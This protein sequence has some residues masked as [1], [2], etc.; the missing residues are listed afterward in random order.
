MGESK[1]MNIHEKIQEM[2]CELQKMKI[3]K[4]GHNRHMDYKYFEL[5]DLLPMINV[6]MQQYKVSSNIRFSKE[7]AVLTFINTEKPEDFS[8]FS[9]PMA[10]SSLKGCH[11]VQNLGASI[12]YIRRYLYIN[13]F[14]IVEK[15]VLDGSEPLQNSPKSHEDSPKIVSK[16]SAQQSINEDGDAQLRAGIT[17]MLAVICE[18]DELVMKDALKEYSGFE[19]SKGRVEVS[20]VAKLKG[21]WLFATY[22]KIK[23]EYDSYIFSGNPP[24]S[25]EAI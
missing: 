15:D 3:I 18:G 4:S 7:E 10:D 25:D 20:D 6:L 24:T 9:C 16:P 8:I 5:Q 17:K 23:D 21:K 19:G 13:A 1:N 12:T 2:R 11:P 14:E 22:N